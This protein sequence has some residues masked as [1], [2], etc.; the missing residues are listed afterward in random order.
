MKESPKTTISR[1]LGHLVFAACLL[2]SANIWASGQTA[3]ASDIDQAIAFLRQIDPAKVKESDKESLAKRIQTAWETVQKAGAPAKVRLKEE[4]AKPGQPD[5]AKLNLAALLWTLSDLDEAGTIASVW[6][7]TKLEVQSNYVFYPAFQAALKQDARALP[8]LRAVLGDQKFG[9][10]V[11]LHSMEVKWPLTEEFIWGAYGPKGVRELLD[12]LQ[13]SHSPGEIQSAVF[14]LA[15]AQAIEALPLIRQVARTANGQTRGMAIHAL[16]QFGDPGDYD[17]L[18]AGLHSK[19]PLD[20]FYFADALYEF[21]DLRAV[22]EMIPLLDSPDAKLRHEV[23]AG[24]THLLTSQ[25]L[26]ALIKHAQR[27][28]T[29]DKA[30]IDDYLQ[31]EL[32]EYKLTIAA[33][34]RKSPSDK[35]TAVETLRRQREARRFELPKNEKGIS[36]SQFLKAAEE[37]KKSAHMKMAA[38]E[39]PLHT[40]QL[41]AVTTVDDMPLLLEIKAAVLGRLS[42]ECLYEVR[43]IHETLQR[44]GRSRYR[45]E[46]GI[47]AKAEAL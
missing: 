40:S 36:R 29:E 34:S 16:G 21:E 44:L 33:Y 13:N 17:F 7:T 5:Y 32:Q 8:M 18:I 31:S 23:F 10:Y 43:A 27:A 47:T 9:V 30:E 4:L 41:L 1:H 11:A 22:P 19:D 25:S 12:V 3:S 28:P 37:M 2:I 45:K 20:A 6:R 26:D 38:S 15:E 42:D 46:V 14:L 24:L 35:A 39:V